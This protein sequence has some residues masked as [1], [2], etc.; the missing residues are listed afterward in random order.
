M[1]MRK[2]QKINHGRKNK[3]KQKICHGLTRNYTEISRSIISHGTKT[4]LSEPDAS[5][6]VSFSEPDA[7]ATVVNMQRR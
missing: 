7:S 2:R 5:A 6:T 4:L 1:K 3:Q